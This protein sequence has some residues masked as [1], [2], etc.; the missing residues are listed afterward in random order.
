MPEPLWISHRGYKRSDPENTL[1]AFRAAVARGFTALETDLRLTADGH[2]VLHHDPNLRRMTGD[3]REVAALR[4]VELA[5]L[6]VTGGG[7]LLFFD[8]FLEEFPGQSWVFDVKP[9]TGAEVIKSLGELAKGRGLT[10]LL[11]AQAKFVTWTRRQELLLQ[12]HFPRAVCYAREPE[13]W[14]AGLALL[15]RARPLM[16]L[17]SSRTYALPPRLGRISLYTPQN[18]ETFHRAGAKVIA[19]LPETAA[20]VAQALKSGVDE[21]L[22]NGD[23]EELQ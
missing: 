20:E 2:I 21:I 11:V 19:F 1:G 4:R 10:D 16:G 15:A 17:R 14:R 6:T 8:E 18:V 22:T 12:K 13:C 9:E 23:I 5:S 3:L 7:R